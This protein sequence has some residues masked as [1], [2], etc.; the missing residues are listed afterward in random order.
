[1]EG[2]WR[3]DVITASFLFPLPVLRERAGVRAPSQTEKRRAV[4]DRTLTLSL[5]RRT[6]RGD[7]SGVP[8]VVRMIEVRHLTKIYEDPDGNEVPALVDASWSCAAG[9]IF[10]LLG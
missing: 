8:T 7:Q 1:M 10:G 5:S 4:S 9:E 3:R 6:G 2:S